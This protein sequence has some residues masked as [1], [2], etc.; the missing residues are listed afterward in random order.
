[1][2]NMDDFETLY[3]TGASS[4]ANVQRPHR[5]TGTDV[6]VK[7]VS[8]AGRIGSRTRENKHYSSVFVEKYIYSL[9]DKKYRSLK[10]STSYFSSVGCGRAGTYNYEFAYK[11]EVPSVREPMSQVDHNVYT[12][13]TNNV[14]MLF[15]A[16]HAINASDVNK[17]SHGGVKSIPVST[18]IDPA[19]SDVVPLDG[20]DSMTLDR[21]RGLSYQ[22]KYTDP[23]GLALMAKEN[24]MSAMAGKVTNPYS[25]ARPATAI[26]GN[27][28]V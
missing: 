10:P 14:M 7:A 22:F 15:D 16:E 20:P 19:V 8:I 17:L 25:T 12:G 27:Q 9:H 28:A 24:F 4:G 1:M 13:G 21:T 11:P 23:S 6:H 18:H 2:Y 26:V 3:D 5:K